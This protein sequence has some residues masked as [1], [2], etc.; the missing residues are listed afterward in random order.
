MKVTYTFKDMGKNWTLVEYFYEGEVVHSFG[1]ATPHAEER[2]KRD[3]KLV[4]EE[5][6]QKID[7]E[8]KKKRISN[9][10]VTYTFTKTGVDTT[11]VKYFHEGKVVH[12]FTIATQYAEEKAKRDLQKVIGWIAQEINREPRK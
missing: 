2:A 1:I 12:S 5:I 11:Q 9:I 6:K 8:E 7:R 4:I 3:L 10:K